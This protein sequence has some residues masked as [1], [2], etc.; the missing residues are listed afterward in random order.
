MAERSEKREEPT[1]L[2]ALESVGV[3]CA[4][5][6]MVALVVGM[7]EGL[8]LGH[9]VGAGDAG[10]GL[11]TAGLWVPAALIALVPGGALVKVTGDAR[12]RT[13][14]LAVLGAAIVASVVV[15]WTQPSIEVST[16]S[17]L[18]ALPLE[19]SGAIAAAWAASLIRFEGLMRRPAALVGLAIAILVQLFANRWVDAH[20]ALA[21]VMV[22]A[23][24]VPRF[25]LRVVLRRFV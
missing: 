1:S 12:R 16:G 18:R 25:M 21:G 13:I 17:P 7:I 5:A 9:R 19:I 23:S 11:A 10:I 24:Y 8:A 4:R 6:S 3:A 22:E 14:V 15:A 20:R 2:S